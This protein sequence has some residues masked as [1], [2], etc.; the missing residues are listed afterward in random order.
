LDARALFSYAHQ[1]RLLRSGW[2][3]RIQG[4]GRGG[5]A[6]AGPGGGVVVVWLGFLGFGGVFFIVFFGFFWCCCV[7]VW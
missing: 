3:L 6:N 7:W 5:R 1:A 2:G 4:V